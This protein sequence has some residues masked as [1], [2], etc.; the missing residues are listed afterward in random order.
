MLRGSR[1]FEEMSYTGSQ[2]SVL[3]FL[4]PTRLRL[5]KEVFEVV[6]PQVAVNCC[7][8]Y[9]QAENSDISY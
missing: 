5:L 6:F 2:I 7:V 3:M 8:E 4:H 9:H 1:I